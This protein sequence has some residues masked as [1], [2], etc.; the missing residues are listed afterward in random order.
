MLRPTPPW[1]RDYHKNKTSRRRRRLLLWKEDD[2]RIAGEGRVTV[3][4]VP[5]VGTDKYVLEP[6]MEV[7][8]D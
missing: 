8:R 3:I 2:V 6:S 1:T 7:V 4:G 5:I